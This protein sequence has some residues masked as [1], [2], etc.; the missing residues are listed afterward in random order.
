MKSQFFKFLGLKPK[1]KEPEE[2]ESIRKITEKL[3][4]LDPA[5]AKYHALFA[6]ILSRVA[7][8]DFDISE[9]ETK[10]MEEIL[11]KLG[12]L[13]PDLSILVTEIAKCQNK[14]LGGVE[15]FL[16][17]REFLKTSTREQCEELLEC[18]FAVAAADE[19]VTTLESNE[20]RQI[21]AELKLEHKDYI[22]VRSRYREHLEVLK[23]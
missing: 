22:A 6:C 20:I 8:V 4:S 19:S 14:L 9:E 16:L 13:S 18:L 17:T 5:I 21:A 11:V 2:T 15:N 10:K 1:E 12:H 7:H 3:A 23:K